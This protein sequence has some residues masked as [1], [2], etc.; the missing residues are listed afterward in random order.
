MMATISSQV[1]WS[2][3]KTLGPSQ[4]WVQTD[5]PFLPEATATHSHTWH[6]PIETETTL[7][8]NSNNTSNCFFWGVTRLWA[9]KLWGIFRVGFCQTS[10]HYHYKTQKLCPH[11]PSSRQ[12]N[13]PAGL[14]HQAP[15]E[16]NGC[17]LFPYSS[18]WAGTSRKVS[19]RK[20][21]DSPIFSSEI[22][23]A[24]P[25]S[26]QW[27]MTQFHNLTLSKCQAT[28]FVPRSIDPGPHSNSIFYRNISPVVS[29]EIIWDYDFYILSYLARW[30]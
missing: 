11:P 1:L 24:Q 27:K 9:E 26:L 23:E 6:S 22:T 5:S 2:W 15:K 20:R 28:K 4:K 17:W 14:L 8:L 25:C 7:Q 16:N 10:L 3:I 13:N 12:N 21:G 29:Q 30:T 19:E 18:V